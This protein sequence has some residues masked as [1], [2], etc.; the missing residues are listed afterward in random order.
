MRGLI[1]GRLDTGDWVGQ[2]ELE[3]GCSLRVSQLRREDF[4]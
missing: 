2:V 3:S 4:W 1:W